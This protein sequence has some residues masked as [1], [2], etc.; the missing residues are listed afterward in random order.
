MSAVVIRRGF[1]DGPSGQIHYREAGSGPPLVLLHLNSGTS[2]MYLPA[3]RLLASGFRAI[4]MDYPGYGDSDAPQEPYTELGQWA[5]SVVA[6]LDGLGIDQAH[7]AGHMTGAQ[8]AAEVAARYP[9][10]V[11]R[12]ILSEVFNWNTPER[13]AAHEA[14]HVAIPASKDFPE[15]RSIWEGARRTNKQEG[16]SVDWE[17]TANQF[18]A[19]VRLKLHYFVDPEPA[20]RTYGAM[21]W[22]GAVPYAM[23]RHDVRAAL[24]QVRA[25]TL[26]MHST[27]GLWIRAHESMVAAV[28]NAS[29]HVIA[30]GDGS[31]PTTDPEAWTGPIVDFL[32]SPAS[33]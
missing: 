1:V 27:N 3:V 21:G 6:L 13:R 17:A 16:D 18:I 32:T 22:D 20:R 9:E 30:G 2:T 15:L 12:L 5:A 29:G 25:P 4:A 26:V 28:A 8:V 19:S 24:A 33:A 31:T 11:D 14:L 23:C 10:R 7:L